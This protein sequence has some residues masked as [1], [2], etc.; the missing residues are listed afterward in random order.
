[1][2]GLHTEPSTTGGL[3]EHGRSEPMQA[4]EHS[5]DECPCLR[6]D[7]DYRDFETRVLGVDRD[8]GEA[9]VLRCR[10]CGRHW[11]E[12]FVEYEYLTASGRWLRGVITPEIAASAKATSAK[13]ILEGLEW[14]LRGGSAFG[15]QVFR[16]SGDL[17]LWLYPSPGP[18][19]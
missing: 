4:S 13:R 2:R 12:Y 5:P 1:M 11:L 17:K 9:S 14:Y 19:G 8:Y 10:R 7:V 3:N 6:G 15:G 16:T 18:R